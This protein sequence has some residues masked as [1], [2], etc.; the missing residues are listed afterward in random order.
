MFLFVL[1][2]LHIQMKRDL[3][4]GFRF[5]GKVNFHFDN[6]RTRWRKIGTVILYDL[7]ASCF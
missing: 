4:E 3:W 2:A 1:M 6:V 7:V 5:A